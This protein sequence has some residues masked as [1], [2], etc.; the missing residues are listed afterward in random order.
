[1]IRETLQAMSSSTSIEEM[2]K[3]L[4]VGQEDVRQRLGL[5]EEK[6]LVLKAGDPAACGCQPAACA[7]CHCSGCSAPSGASYV[8]TEKGMKMLGRA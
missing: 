7:G 4:G 6:G 3:K 8:I 1:M 5:L 2:A